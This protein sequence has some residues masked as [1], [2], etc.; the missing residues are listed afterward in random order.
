MLPNLTAAPPRSGDRFLLTQACTLT[1]TLGLPLTRPQPQHQAP[2][3][4]VLLRDG[5]RG[6]GGGGGRQ[7]RGQG[8]PLALATC[9][10]PRASFLPT[11]LL[12]TFYLPLTYSAKAAWTKGQGYANAY[13]DIVNRAIT[14][15]V[16]DKFPQIEGTV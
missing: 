3:Q 12:P 16:G 13:L 6:R 10:L 9:H 2:G 5:R 7:E 1:L 15:K 4:R 11:A 14:S 8:A